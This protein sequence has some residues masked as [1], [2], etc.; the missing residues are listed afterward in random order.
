M[1]FVRAMDSIELTIFPALDLSQ[2]NWSILAIEDPFVNLMCKADNILQEI[3]FCASFK[4]SIKLS[5]CGTSWDVILFPWFPIDQRITKENAGFRSTFSCFFTGS[6]I[7]V[8]EVD[9]FW[10]SWSFEHWWVFHWP[11]LLRAYRKR[12]ESGTVLRSLTILRANVRCPRAGLEKNWERIDIDY[13]MSALVQVA[14][15]TTTAS[16]KDLRSK[17][18]WILDGFH[19]RRALKFDE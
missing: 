12:T 7:T 4:K 17:Q 5:F 6:K 14:S 11:S 10:V 1:C 9:Q 18:I 19:A 2:K 3:C 15:W 13:E 16:L 8:S